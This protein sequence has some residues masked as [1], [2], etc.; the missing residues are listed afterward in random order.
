MSTWGL[1]PCCRWIL[2]L[3]RA[4][5]SRRGTNNRNRFGVWVVL[6]W[7]PAKLQAY[8]HSGDEAHPGTRLLQ[9]NLFPRA[10][11]RRA[12]QTLCQLDQSPPWIRHR[13][14]EHRGVW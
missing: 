9:K 5:M 3:D 7:R 2:H 11:P 1:L 8:L 12:L 10:L 4:A 14:C 13:G 6:P